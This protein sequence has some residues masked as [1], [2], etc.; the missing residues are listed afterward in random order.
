MR[1]DEL[2]NGLTFQNNIQPQYHYVP[3]PRQ[4][5]RS[6]RVIIVSLIH[7]VYFLIIVYSLTVVYVQSN[8]TCFGQRAR[9]VQ[10]IVTLSLDLRQP[11]GSC[12]LYWWWDPP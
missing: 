1:V 5:N 10:S 9:I 7:T 6:D 2:A 8:T 11:M 3:C 12:M 4:T